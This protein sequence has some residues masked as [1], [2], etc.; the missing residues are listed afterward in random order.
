MIFSVLNIGLVFSDA[1]LR[2]AMFSL[3]GLARAHV[4]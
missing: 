1:K 3:Y 2:F 4:S